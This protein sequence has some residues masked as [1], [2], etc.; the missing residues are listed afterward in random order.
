MEIDEIVY[1]VHAPVDAQV[2][3]LSSLR[4]TPVPVAANS[5]AGRV[6]CC[7]SAVM[8]PDPAGRPGLVEL[9]H[10]APPSLLRSTPAGV[11]VTAAN[12]APDP[13]RSK[14]TAETYRASVG[15]QLA[16]RSV[17]R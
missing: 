6:G 9:S 10:V 3:P 14:I 8:L 11:P 13:E 5:V 12:A 4:N 16:P 1:P 17:D 15:A 2:T 7:A